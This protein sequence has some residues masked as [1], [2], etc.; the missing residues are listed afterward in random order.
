MTARGDFRG[1]IEQRAIH[2]ALVPN[3]AGATWVSF[4]QRFDIRAGEC[5]VAIIGLD[6]ALKQCTLYVETESIRGQRADKPR[7]TCGERID[8]RGNTGGSSDR[9]R[10]HGTIMNEATSPNAVFQ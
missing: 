3:G 7:Q 8:E 2:R 10:Y 4:A 9:R 6:N 5:F 1:A